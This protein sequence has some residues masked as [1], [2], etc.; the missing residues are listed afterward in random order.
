MGTVK[1]L[2]KTSLKEKTKND[3][4]NLKLTIDYY[5][6]NVSEFYTTRNK[7]W[8]MY[9]LANGVFDESYYNYV[10]NPINS[11]KE[12]HRNFPARIRNY[13]II[14]PLLRLLQGEKSKRPFPYQ[15]FVHNEDSHITK[16]ED[17]NAAM[18]AS[19][20]QMFI[21]Q[22]NAEGMETGMETQ[23]TEPPKKIQEEME[24]TWADKRAKWGQHAL[25][26]I[27]DNEDVED[28]WEDQFYD[29]MACDYAFSYK[30]VFN[31]DV[32]YERVSPFEIS[33]VADP[34]TKYIEDGEAAIRRSLM[35][36]NSIIDRF[37]DLLTDKDIDDLEST[38]RISIGSYVQP[39]SFIHR[40]QSQPQSS[41]LIEVVHVVF[42]SLRKIGRVTRISLEGELEEFEVDELYVAADD[43]I[44][45]WRW[46]SQ[47]FEGYKINDEIYTG[48]QMIPNL[49]GSFDNPSKCK[50]PYNGICFANRESKSISLVE[51]M[52]PYQILYN[53]VHYRLELSLAKNKD[54]LTIMPLGL[55]P[56]KKDM[57]MF[58]TMYYSDSTGYLFF[59]ETKKNAIQS[60]QYVKT[61]DTSLAQSIQFSSQF[62]QE[63]KQNLEDFL[64]ISRQRKGQ[65]SSSDGLGNSERAIF[66]SSIITEV[67]FS[68]MDKFQGKELQGFLDLARHAWKRGKKGQYISSDNELQM[69]D[70][71]EEV[72]AHSELGVFARVSAR[73]QEKLQELKALAQPF[74][75]NGVKPT[76]IA[77]I[78]SS[79]N[80]Q[81]LK[82]KLD[83]FE[84]EEEAKQ[85]QAQ[86]AQNEAM[87][88][89]EG[90]KAE[91]DEANRLFEMDKQ[92]KDL[93][94]KR[95]E[96]YAKLTHELG[97]MDP[98]AAKEQYNVSLRKIAEDERSNKADERLKNKEIDT[99]KEVELKK[100]AK[101][102]ANRKT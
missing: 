82:S 48:I 75:Q 19:I 10:T 56:D 37:G 49:R 52:M 24:R 85:Q 16:R 27:I 57:D 78:I 55:I 81:Y 51:R 4:E 88:E 43:E 5:K 9:E 12:A 94:F 39:S 18:N 66:Q 91:N 67:L 53:I 40:D 14:T 86:Q 42:K 30:D 22:L 45:E 36:V 34:N 17:I 90:I 54:K 59:D 46:I 92:D 100:I 68:R 38:Q 8:K 96:L 3:N 60:L 65:I 84:R 89:A 80:F 41:K 28:K 26:Y 29:M 76:V 50:L 79:D 71:P 25:S 44:I 83:R 97:K 61:L 77:D 70:I 63:I 31:N 95:E 13:D 87:I 2:Q 98:N 69:F 72:F 32:T 64:G 102:S 33:Y 99:K 20:Q 23:E 101:M 93:D 58:D 73:E 21:N 1:P 74:A 35:S 62:L 6:S 11:G 47:V 15:V 7:F